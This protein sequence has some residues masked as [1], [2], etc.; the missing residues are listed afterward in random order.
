L[1]NL[2]ASLTATVADEDGLMQAWLAPGAQL[3]MVFEKTRIWFT[4]GP[5][6]YEIE[7][8][9]QA[10]AF[11]PVVEEQTTVEG[12][13][14]GRISFTTD[15]RLLLLSLAEPVLRNGDRGQGQIPTNVAAAERL[16][17]TQT[18]FNRKLDNVC[19]KL[20]KQGVRGLHGDASRLAAN[21]R[22]RL[23]EY[24]VAARLVTKADLIV[25]DSHEGELSPSTS[26]DGSD[27]VPSTSQRSS[28]ELRAQQA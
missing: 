11:A 1:S 27:N 5:T 25:L 8:F 19:Q 23:V 14:M 28:G 22:A 3:P 18:K 10:A 24:A 21:R 4:A 6:T 15:Q 12:T 17:W 7:L 9:L 13:T 26:Q 16:G 2:G 20:V